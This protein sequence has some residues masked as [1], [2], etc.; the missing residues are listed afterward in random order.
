MLE[1]RGKYNSAK[2][3]TDNVEETAMGQIIELCNQPF[4]EGSNIRIMPDTHAGAG[5][6]IGTTM[7][8][9]DKIVPNLVGVDIGC[10][11]EV[12]IID[13]NKTEINFDQ[14]D[15]IIRKYVPSGFN[16][17]S[18]SQRHPLSKQVN[19]RD[20]RAPFK[21]DRAKDS[22]GTLGG[23]NH[24][25]ELNELD[26]KVVL[27]IHSG[28][29]N[30][31]KQIAEHY[32]NRAYDELINV[33]DEKDR[34]I[35]E[36]I[37]AGRQSEIQKALSVVKKPKIQKDLAYLEGQGFKDYMNDMKIAQ[38]YA[39]LNRKAMVDE[40]VTRMNW[41]VVDSFTTI[42]NYIDM[43][44][45]ILR[46]GAISAQA[47]ERVII[48]LNMR[49]G[50]IIAYGKGNPDWNFSGPHGAG[51]LMSRSKAKELVSLEEYKETMKDVWT[52][53]VVQ[54]T[55]DESPMAYK[56]MAE[57]VEHT[58][59]SLEIAEIIKPLYNFKAH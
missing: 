24:F 37:A 7:T 42:H 34:I 14:L 18:S 26:D 25:V 21:L 31:G 51:R 50:S 36:L 10:G 46:K 54:S 55:V 43:D 17:R 2:V 13:K 28:S 45:M 44:N 58:K 9:T 52:T 57:I 23:G 5:C 56:P 19:F 6:T 4:A 30:L 33:K 59:D 41:K 40:I 22:I 11:M 39:L 1:L 38:H 29:R 47:G 32:Q 15:E 49:D 16:V 12:A 35:A 53:S 3:F 20:V 48:P 8:I 27:V